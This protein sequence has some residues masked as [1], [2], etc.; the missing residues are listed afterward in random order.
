MVRRRSFFPGGPS[1]SPPFPPVRGFLP[2]C[3]R[4]ASLPPDH[5]RSGSHDGRGGLVGS[6][7]MVIATTA[8][9]RSRSCGVS[10]APLPT[11]TAPGAAAAPVAALP[12]SGFAA[13][14]STISASLANGS[15]SASSSSAR[16]ARAAFTVRP[17]SRSDSA[18]ATE[19]TAANEGGVASRLPPMRGSRPSGPRGPSE[20]CLYC[21]L[22]SALPRPRPPPSKAAYGSDVAR[23]AAVAISPVAL[24]PCRP[25]PLPAPGLLTLPLTMTCAT[26]Q[27]QEGAGGGRQQ[28]GRGGSR[29]K[30][31]EAGGRTRWRQD[32]VE[33]ENGKEEGAAC[34]K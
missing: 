1:A 27:R 25:V 4:E 23:E 13:S 14:T 32:E 8:E 18:D 30:Q 9:I 2:P 33:G 6:V 29:W 34:T 21:V 5:R 3:R 15:T 12:S 28:A 26:A 11:P 7:S 17:I 19:R 16:R 20:G 31:V 10:R 22:G 24:R